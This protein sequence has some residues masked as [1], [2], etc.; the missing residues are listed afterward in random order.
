MEAPKS[1]M[2]VLAAGVFQK[3]A[4]KLKEALHRVLRQPDEE[5]VHDVR[6]ACRR[7]NVALA[8]TETMFR[9]PVVKGTRERVK[10]LL[11]FLG[12]LRDAEVQSERVRKLANQRNTQGLLRLAECMEA[13]TE[14]LRLRMLAEIERGA[15]ETLPRLI[16]VLPLPAVLR[17]RGSD[18]NTLSAAQAAQRVLLE[19]MIEISKFD[20]LDHT[21]PSEKLHELRIA[22]KRLRYSADF[23]ASAL[24]TKLDHVLEISKEF[25]EVLGQLHDAD[26][27]ETMLAP[28]LRREDGADHGVLYSGVREAI[29]AARVEQEKL[30][31]EFGA[32]RQSEK[33]AVVRSEI[34]N[35]VPR[36]ATPGLSVP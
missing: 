25:Q 31:E 1:E 23:F 17:R 19:R 36:V 30:R 10:T 26:V 3:Q 4:L 24:D 33:L 18:L 12:E 5:A 11:R 20:Y 16:E 15:F 29:A 21:G 27:T 34:D 13:H 7:L 35:L 8:A 9:K 22:F 28:M 2:L 6:V 32:L 14:L